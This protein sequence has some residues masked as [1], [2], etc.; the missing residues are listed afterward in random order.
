MD[1]REY[2]C[3]TKILKEQLIPATGCTEPIALAY[4]AAVGRKTPWQAPRKGYCCGQRQHCQKCKER[5][6]SRHRRDEG[7]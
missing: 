3:Y 1:T 6:G 5:G 2:A 7:Y 4:A